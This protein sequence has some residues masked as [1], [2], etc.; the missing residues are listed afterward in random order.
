M[1]TLVVIIN[2]KL[3]PFEPL[4]FIRIT[5]INTII[6]DVGSNPTFFSIFA[7]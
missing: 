6:P 7:L 2:A 5:E 3:Y 4:A 1:I